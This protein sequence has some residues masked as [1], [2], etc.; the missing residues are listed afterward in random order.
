MN[1]VATVRYEISEDLVEGRRRFSW[2]NRIV[3]DAY[4]YAQKRRRTKGERP[5]GDGRE[6]VLDLP[7][8]QR[9]ALAHGPS[10]LKQRDNLALQGFG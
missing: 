1:C 5:A 10:P 9:S 8:P 6:S 3:G 2:V 4:G 7:K